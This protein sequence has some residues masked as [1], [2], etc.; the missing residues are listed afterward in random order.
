MWSHA[1]V[2]VCLCSN[3]I[4]IGSFLGRFE[5]HLQHQLPTIHCPLPASS[6]RS[7]MAAWRCWVPSVGWATCPS[8]HR[9]PRNGTRR[10]IAACSSQASLSGSPLAFLSGPDQSQG[11]RAV[12]PKVRPFLSSQKQR[13]RGFWQARLTIVGRSS[14]VPLTFVVFEHIPPAIR[15]AVF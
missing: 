15:R 2:D 5:F 9:G 6:S 7:S 3:C 13:K 14:L 11:R 8:S 12:R 1:G 10:A 4:R